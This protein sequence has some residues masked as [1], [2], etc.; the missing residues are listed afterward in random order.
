MFSRNTVR[1]VR[2]HYHELEANVKSFLITVV[3]HYHWFEQVV[4][5]IVLELQ[6]RKFQHSK[7]CSV[8]TPVKK[9]LKLRHVY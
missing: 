4:N 8:V 3:S 9:P 6:V 1:Y 5:T 7:L 2:L